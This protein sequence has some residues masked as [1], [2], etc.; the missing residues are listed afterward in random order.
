MPRTVNT[1]AGGAAVV[2]RS[3]SN[4]SVSVVPFTDAALTSGSGWF[5]VS[6]LTRPAKPTASL[7]A[8]SRSPSLDGCS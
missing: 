7:P 6:F 1:L 8:A 2:S 4:V 3:S 5:A